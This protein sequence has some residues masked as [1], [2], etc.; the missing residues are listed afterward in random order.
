MAV[1]T[2]KGM[3]GMLWL[4]RH[5]TAGPTTDAKDDDKRPLDPMGRKEA[6]AA[7]VT[8]KELKTPIQYCMASPLRRAMETAELVCVELGLDVVPEAKLAGQPLSV[9]DVKT[10][11]SGHGNCLL[12]SHAPGVD[13]LVYKFT[14]A[15]AQ[16][17]KGGLAQ[18]HEGELWT[19]LNA[20]TCFAMAGLSNLFKDP[21]EVDH[22]SSNDWVKEKVREKR[23]W[24][25]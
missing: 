25:L 6:S 19:L 22:R 5:A 10:L 17:T 16:L 14:G 11:I 20:S 4:M 2:S 13:L 23:N 8:L 9:A 1:N 18:I 12:V 21:Q 3:Q 24:R 15:Q 7:G